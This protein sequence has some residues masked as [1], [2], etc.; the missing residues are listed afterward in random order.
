[1]NLSLWLLAFAAGFYAL[2]FL[3]HMLS[4]SSLQEEGH[5]PAFVF[6]RIGFLIATFYFAAAAIENGFFLPVANL[7]QAMAFFAWSLAFVYLVL[8]VKAQSESFGLILTP[9]LLLLTVVAFVSR[10][11]GTSPM[12]PKPVLLNPY[13]TLHIATAFFAYASFTISFAAGVLYLIQYAELKAKRAGKFYHKLTSL[14]DLERLIYQ[15]MLWGAPLLGVA[16][17]IGF[18]WSKSVFG[19]FWIFD[20]KTIA[21]G[22]TALLYIVILY[23][24]YV[25]S[26]RGKQG[27]VL[28]LIAFAL[29]LFSFVGT[30]LIPGSHNYLQ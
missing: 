16:A 21:T 19:E 24:R 22:V 8:L 17:G 10:V 13:F 15:P 6:M 29:V 23:L 18:L 26:M 25:S 20:P 12:P 7:S 14:E 2:A 28:S 27:A 1:M 9:I 30:R 11:F 5:K 4:F 3:F